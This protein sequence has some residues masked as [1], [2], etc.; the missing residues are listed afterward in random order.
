MIWRRDVSENGEH[1]MGNMLWDVE[2]F[3]EFVTLLR[4]INMSRIKICSKHEGYSIYVC[5]MYVKMF[6][7]LHTC[8]CEVGWGLGGGGMKD[9]F[10]WWRVWG[11]AS[12][13]TAAHWWAANSS[14][15]RNK[16]WI[17]K[18]IKPNSDIDNYNSNKI[19]IIAMII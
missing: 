11:S 17:I 19:V 4:G 12:Q 10:M 2:R 9:F 3:C 14:K 7:A 16:K 15:N 18:G 5:I 13:P 8:T 1:V 6:H